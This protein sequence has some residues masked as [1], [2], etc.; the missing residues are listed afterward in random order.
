MCA[1]GLIFYQEHKYYET[2]QLAVTITG[3]AVVCVGISI[4]FLKPT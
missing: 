4:F 2:W 1:S 3:S